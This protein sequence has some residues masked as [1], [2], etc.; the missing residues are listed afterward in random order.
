[1]QRYR[2]ISSGAVAETFLSAPAGK[3]LGD[4]AI[5]SSALQQI[6]GISNCANIQCSHIC[7]GLGESSYRCLCPKGLKLDSDGI[8]C[9]GKN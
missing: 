6:N 9:I 7:V 1:M 5:M 2:I 8:T 4:I 3:K